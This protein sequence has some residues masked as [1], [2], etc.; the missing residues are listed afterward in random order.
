[1]QGDGGMHP[2]KPAFFKDIFGEGI[3]EQCA[4]NVSMK[5]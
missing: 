5:N 1:M 4:K 3:V 2:P